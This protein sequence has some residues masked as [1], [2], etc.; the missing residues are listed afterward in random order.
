[1]EFNK[2]DRV[3]NPK[4]LGWGVGEVLEDT[5]GGDRV[6]VFFVGAGEKLI[7]LNHVGLEKVTGLEAAHMVLDNLKLPKAGEV[8]KYHSLEESVEFFKA[9]FPEGF[10][11]DKYRAHERDYKDKAHRLFVEELGKDVFGQLLAEERFDEISRRALRLCNATNLIFPNEK[12]A[13]KGGLL[14]SDNQKRFSLGLYD[15]LYGEGELEP[16]FTAFA[17]VLEHLN[18]AKW[19]TM[20]YFL[21][22]A[23]P[24]THMFVKPTI[25]KHASELSAFEINYKPELNW[26]TYKSILNFSRYLASNLEALEP[27]DMIDIQSFMWCIAPGNY[28]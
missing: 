23:H 27:R 10:Y 19:T 13:L 6:R 26:L 5:A 15:L 4:M 24:D 3:R 9:E 21:F 18:A 11:G 12:M 22:F 16:R 1:M 25:A 17:R 8:I 2:G 14:E 20:T 28:S 7:S